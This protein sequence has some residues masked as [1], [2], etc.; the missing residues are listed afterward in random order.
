MFHKDW[1]CVNS[2]TSKRC[3]Y[4]YIYTIYSFVEPPFTIFVSHLRFSQFPRFKVWAKRFAPIL[5]PWVVVNRHLYDRIIEVGFPDIKSWRSWRSR[6]QLGIYSSL[7]TFLIKL[8]KSGKHIFGHG[9]FQIQM[10]CNLIRPW[11]QLL[12]YQWLKDLGGFDYASSVIHSH[13]HTMP[14][15][16]SHLNLNS[17][18][19]DC[20]SWYDQSLYD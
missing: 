4:I 20:P 14:I 13:V 17:W 1:T 16:P 7:V 8:R 15:A 6:G 19:T 11:S 9:Y 2:I 12:R 3:I 10:R 18:N 5:V